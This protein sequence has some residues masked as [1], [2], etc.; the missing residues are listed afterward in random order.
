MSRKGGHEETTVEPSPAV[1]HG[2]GGLRAADGDEERAGWYASNPWMLAA[3]V[4]PLL[5]L[6][7][8]G[9]FLLMRRKL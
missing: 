6:V 2:G 1:E 8:V 7:L 5:A 3:L 4:I 9:A